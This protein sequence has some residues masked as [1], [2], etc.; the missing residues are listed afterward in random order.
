MRAMKHWILSAPCQKTEFGFRPSIACW[1]K[2]L[3]CIL[4]SAGA[5][6]QLCA[7]KE[8]QRELLEPQRAAVVKTH[9]IGGTD[10][11]ATLHV[12]RATDHGTQLAA[13]S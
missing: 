6:P 2:P 10:G 13:L 5:A 8:P 12:K 1:T 3:P 7:G 11:A 9:L 4:A